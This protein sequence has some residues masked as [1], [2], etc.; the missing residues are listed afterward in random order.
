MKIAI[1]TKNK[2]IDTNYSLCKNYSI[3][4]IEGR[5]ITDETLFTVPDDCNCKPKIAVKFL[6]MGVS[7]LLV[8]KISE[9]DYDMLRFHTIEVIRGCKCLAHEAVIAYLKGDII[10]SF[11]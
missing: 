4:S 1:P 8:D 3:F 7:V 11:E 6:E 2:N 9:G 10:D 5:K